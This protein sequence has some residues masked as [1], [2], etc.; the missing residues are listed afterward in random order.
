MKTCPQLL[1]NYSQAHFHKSTVEAF[2]CLTSYNTE[3][4]YHINA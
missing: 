2:P 4:D 3:L 1:L